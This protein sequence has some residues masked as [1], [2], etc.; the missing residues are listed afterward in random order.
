MGSSSYNSLQIKLEKTVQV[1]WMIMG[2][3][4]WAKLI[5]D[6]DTLNGF[7]EDNGGVGSSG[8]N[9]MTAGLIVRSR[10]LTLRTAFK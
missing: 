4:T 10:A 8:Q 6:T 5:S 2:S 7:L 1:R 9:A 3:Y